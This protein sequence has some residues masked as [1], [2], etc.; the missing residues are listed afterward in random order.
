[1]SYGRGKSNSTTKISNLPTSYK[2][3]ID[4]SLIR[5]NDTDTMIL[6][7]MLHIWECGVLEY[8][9]RIKKKK[10]TIG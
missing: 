8:Q 10:P 6:S 4:I 9:K 7:K 5:A 1:M 2:V 3:L